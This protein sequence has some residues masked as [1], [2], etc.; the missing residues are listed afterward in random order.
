MFVQNLWASKCKNGT[1][2]I[3]IYNVYFLLMLFWCEVCMIHILIKDP[4]NYCDVILHKIMWFLCTIHEHSYMSFK[5]NVHQFEYLKYSI[6]T[7]IVHINMAC[8]ICN[9]CMNLWKPDF[10]WNFYEA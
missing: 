5:N 9:F 2:Y 3:Y 1:I 4:C 10:A 8:N 6:H 7:N